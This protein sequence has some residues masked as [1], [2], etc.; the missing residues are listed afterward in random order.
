MPAF[1]SLRQKRGFTFLELLFV[2]IILGILLGVSLP[3]FK[4]SYQAFQFDAFTGQFAGLFN[5]LRQ[6]S[7]VE[8]KII[9]LEFDNEKKEYWSY[10]DQSE[11]RLKTYPI[12]DGV[13]LEADKDEVLFYPDGNIDKITINIVSPDHKEVSLTT[14]GVWGG[15][16]V[17][18]AAQ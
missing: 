15:V 9:H 7:M 14:E 17:N 13:T 1:G 11:A 16:K 2:V 6:R 12:P 3:Q 4:K 18:K 8:S 5:Y 10:F